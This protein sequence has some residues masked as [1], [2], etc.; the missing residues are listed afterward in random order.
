[1]ENYEEKT[2]WLKEIKLLRKQKGKLSPWK[3]NIFR[4]LPLSFTDYAN[5]LLVQFW[6]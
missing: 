6:R 3:M 1:M 4:F 5:N 2:R